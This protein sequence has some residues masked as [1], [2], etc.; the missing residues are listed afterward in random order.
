[1]S[2]VHVIPTHDIP[3]LF[4]N[5]ED[6]VEKNLYEWNLY[7]CLLYLASGPACIFNPLELVNI[8]ENVYYVISKT[9]YGVYL[10]DLFMK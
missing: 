6:I 9:A 1:M 5:S 4:R 2:D 8:Q 7:C 10:Q 3:D